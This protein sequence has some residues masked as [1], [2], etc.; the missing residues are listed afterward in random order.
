MTRAVAVCR[1]GLSVAAAAVLLSACGGAGNDTSA[2]SSSSA[3]SSASGASA[4]ATGS[5]VC[6]PAAGGGAAGPAGP[7][8]PA[9]P[10]PPPQAPKAAAAEFRGQA[11]GVESTVPAALGN[12]SDPASIPKALKA[13]AAEIR[14]IDPPNE[15]ASDWTAL[16]D[17]VEQIATAF[18]NVD[19][20]N[21]SALAIFEQRA[22]QLENQLSTAS[23]NVQ[24]YLAD[25]C[26]LG[27]PAE[28]AAPTS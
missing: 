11:A 20:S 18:E 14:S 19:L 22:T 5:G 23:T 17:G 28:S 15:I 3:R 9:D 21:P 26:G 10:P 25:K 1:S 16:A 6:R 4:T 8:E 2:S 12:Q 13:A 24:N 7:G 27:T